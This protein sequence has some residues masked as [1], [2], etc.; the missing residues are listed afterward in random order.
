[1]D[2]KGLFFC[3]Q[4]QCPK[5]CCGP[6]DGISNQLISIDSR[7]F[8]EIVLTQDDTLRLTQNGFSHYFEVDYSTATK[9]AYRKMVLAD[10]GTCIAFQG[11]KCTIHAISPTLCKAFPF[12]YDMF[13]G[14]CVITCAGIRQFHKDFDI[15][16]YDFY[17]QNAK[18]M[19]EFWLDFYSV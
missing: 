2:D 9:K 7:P 5:S 3:L 8:R 15:L 13:S 14:L 6:F 11:G 10:D 4:D 17:I 18:K 1:M 16:K 19:Y 12:Y